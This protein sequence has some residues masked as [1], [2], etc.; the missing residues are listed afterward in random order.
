M[1]FITIEEKIKQVNGVNT[2]LTSYNN[3]FAVAAT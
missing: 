3:Q 1:L 2:Q